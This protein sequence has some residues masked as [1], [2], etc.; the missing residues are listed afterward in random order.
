MRIWIML[1]FSNPLSFYFFL[2]VAFD[3]EGLDI[4]SLFSLSQK[5]VS[6]VERLKCIV[7]LHA[8]NHYKCGKTVLNIRMRA[9]K[10][11]G[12]KNTLER[13]RLVSQKRE[14]SVIFTIVVCK[15]SENYWRFTKILK[16]NESCLEK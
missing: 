13:E 2:S 8:K 16:Q 11:V 7:V 6:L 5:Y 12:G 4:K 9:P 1:N 3:L 14:K 15:N 10:G